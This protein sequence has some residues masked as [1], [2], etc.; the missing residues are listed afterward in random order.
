MENNQIP[1]DTVRQALYSV[2]LNATQN[3]LPKDYDDNLTP[4]R[5]KPTNQKPQV[6]R[7]EMRPFFTKTRTKLEQG[8]D[9]A[10]KKLAEGG[11]LEKDSTSQQ[12]FTCK[13]PNSDAETSLSKFKLKKE[14]ISELIELEI[15]AINTMPYNPKSCSR[16]S[17]QNVALNVFERLTDISTGLSQPY[18]EQQPWKATDFERR[19]EGSRS[20]NKKNMATQEQET[21]PA[22]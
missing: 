11:F 2:F 6:L 13:D 22:L 21:S 10:L 15:N 5:N 16:E 7:P 9:K 20:D 19:V 1:E 12:S 17:Y 8:V 14:I 4:N 3:L 18:N